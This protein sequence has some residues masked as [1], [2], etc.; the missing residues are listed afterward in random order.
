M[1][2]LINPKNFK[3]PDQWGFNVEVSLD[4]GCG[5][6]P[7]NPFGARKLYGID[8]LPEVHLQNQR[9]LVEPKLSSDF[10]YIPVTRRSKI[11]FE[12]DFFCAVT[13]FDLLEHLSREPN[14]HANEFI[15]IMNECFRILKKGGIFFAITPAFPSPAAFQDPTHTNFISEMTIHYFAG[16]N[17]GAENLGYGF[18][19]RFNIIDQF[20]MMPFNKVMRSQKQAALWRNLISIRGL[21][22]VVSSIRNPTHL[23]WI[24][25]KF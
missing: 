5:Q 17:P 3:L 18:N 21:R 16:Q 15:F 24:L 8:I 25:Q 20:W 10:E 22:S 13:A 23:V 11:P 4:L 14:P 2:D 19:G 7:R 6:N 1:F 9:L 12:D